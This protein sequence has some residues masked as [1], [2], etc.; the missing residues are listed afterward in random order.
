MP[1]LIYKSFLLSRFLL[2]VPATRFESHIE[3]IYKHFCNNP[4]LLVAVISNGIPI[5]KFMPNS[6]YRSIVD[7]NI[8]LCVVEPALYFKRKNF[9]KFFLSFGK[10][11]PAA[12]LQLLFSLDAAFSSKPLYLLHG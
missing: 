10:L 6:V 2:V 7:F 11:P 9:E 1:I 4:S 3:R 5:P 12:I 8:G